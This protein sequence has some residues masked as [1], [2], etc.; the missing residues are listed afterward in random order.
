[1]HVSLYIIKMHSTLK[2]V[3]NNQSEN[4]C[5]H[6]LSQMT[7]IVKYICTLF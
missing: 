6:T 2:G 3:T 1:M 5:E 4:T 7:H